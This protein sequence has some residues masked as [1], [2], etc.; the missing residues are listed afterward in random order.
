M[1]DALTAN[2]DAVLASLG[3]APEMPGKEKE[4]SE[5]PSED[6]EEGQPTRGLRQRAGDIHR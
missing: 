4:D 1:L 5:D 2:N 6:V 3:G